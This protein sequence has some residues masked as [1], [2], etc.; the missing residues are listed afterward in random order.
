MAD[1]NPQ[2][3]SRMRGSPARDK[4]IAALAKFQGAVE[5]VKKERTATVAGTAKGSGKAYSYR[6]KYADISD[7]LDEIRP[8]SS[9][10]GLAILQPPFIRETSTGNYL[11]VLT[12]IAHESGQWIEADYPVCGIDGAEHQDIQAALTAAKRGALG[13]FIAVAAEVDVGGRDG[14]GNEQ[15]GDPRDPQE[16]GVYQSAGTPPPE[17]ERPRGPPRNVPPHDAADNTAPP[18]D[19]AKK[20]AEAAT[21]EALQSI[22]AAI[23]VD[24]STSLDKPGLLDKWQ[25]RKAAILAETITPAMKTNI[26]WLEW[27]RVEVFAKATNEDDIASEWTVRIEPHLEGRNA[28]TR[29]A[30]RA[31]Y[32]ARLAEL[33]G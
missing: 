22:A 29:Q 26:D 33:K 4:I 28:E 10:F 25:A 20:I 9:K 8:K 18:V 6:Y 27:A 2:N 12:H 3:V 1:V 21:I 17:R 11:Y 32:D 30:A 7:F 19:Y 23:K 13:A 31:L 24:N 5:N 14:G 15:R 16:S